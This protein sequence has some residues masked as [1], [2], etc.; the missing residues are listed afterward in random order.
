MART[1]SLMN[2]FIGDLLQSAGTMLRRWPVRRAATLRLLMR[3]IVVP[4]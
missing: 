3:L 4:P 1:A 2:N